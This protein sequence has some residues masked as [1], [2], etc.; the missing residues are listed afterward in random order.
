MLHNSRLHLT[1]LEFLDESLLA[2]VVILSCTR[3]DQKSLDRAT[4]DLQAK[5]VSY[6]VLDVDRDYGE[7][8]EVQLA[9]ILGSDEGD[10]DTRAENDLIDFA[11][12]DAQRE[13]TAIARAIKNCA[14]L[15]IVTDDDTVGKMSLIHA[16]MAM[17]WKKPIHAITLYKSNV[18]AV[19]TQ[20][21]ATITV[22]YQINDDPNVNR[23]AA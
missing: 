4:Y 5:G 15:V 20:L 3:N 23:K 8:F 17:A 1:E 21:G 22:D 14:R 7:F 19:S 12:K 16:G 13:S 10:D 6:V 11:F 2:D 18:R 9:E